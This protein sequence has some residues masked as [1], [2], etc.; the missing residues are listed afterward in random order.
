M[1]VM[2]GGGADVGRSALPLFE[3]SKARSFTNDSGLEVRL[4]ETPGILVAFV[5]W[6]GGSPLIN[7]KNLIMP[8]SRLFS[9]ALRLVGWS[10]QFGNI[11][12]KIS[13]KFDHWPQLLEDMR[14]LCRFFRNQ[15]YRSHISRKLKGRIDGLSQLLKGFTAGFP[16]WRY[17]TFYGCLRQLLRLRELCERFLVAELVVHA[18]DR[19][20]TRS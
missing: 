4:L 7:V 9:G 6:V 20:H 3:G 16:E 1:G 11:M 18:Q 13:E 12:K 15:T 19:D 8:K 14:E 10:H 5:A 17:K 2:V